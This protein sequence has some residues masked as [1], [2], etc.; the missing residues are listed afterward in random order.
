M[1]LQDFNYHLPQE[2]IA[3][4]PLKKRDEARLMV[5]DRK[6]GRITHDLFLRVGDYLPVKSTL[7]L[8]DSKVIAARLLGNRETGGQVEIFLLN[9]LSDDYSF[10]A[11]IRPLGRLRIDEKIIF[12]GGKIYA[13]LKDAKNKIVRFNRRDI[14]RQLDKIGHVPLPP[15]IK[16]PDEPLDQDFYQTVY[17][18]HQGSVAS[19]T[20][21]LHFTKELL[22]LLKRKGHGIEKLTLH[23]N[24]ATFK[25]VEE[26]DVTQHK[27][28]TESY[29]V[30]SRLVD[31]IE[32]AK[33]SGRKIVAV[34]TTSCRAL[35]AASVTGKLK[36]DTDI[37]IYPGYHFHVT[38]ALI[39]N[40]H[41]PFSTL[42]ILVSAFAGRDLIIKAYDEAIK[43]KYRFYS[44]GDA[45][46]II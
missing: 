25:S 35:E 11:L 16:R 27:M 30:S 31:H 20:A 7:V 17:A 26:E 18:R 28:H 9:R 12:N 37:F 5:V 14:L 39:T 24:Y 44:Y 33:S 34:G 43:Q 36:G 46:L 22:K 41:L 38:D 15:Y 1:K 42:L 8:N 23:I 13:Q 3:Q 4:Y 40:F 19:P 29:S 10:E 21:G 32:K 45:M 6:S 2:L